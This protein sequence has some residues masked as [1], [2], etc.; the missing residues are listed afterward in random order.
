MFFGDQVAGFRLYMVYQKAFVKLLN[1]IVVDFI[2]SL[3]Q[4]K[5]PDSR[6]VLSRLE[7]YIGARQFMKEPDGRSMPK[8]D[9]SSALKC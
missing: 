4:Q 8:S 1:V 9:L 5:D 7:T 2:G 6:A 3:K